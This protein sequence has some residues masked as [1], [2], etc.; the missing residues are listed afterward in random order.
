MTRTRTRGTST[1]KNVGGLA[2]TEEFVDDFLLQSS[3][4]L[5]YIE[6][7]SF[8][9]SVYSRLTPNNRPISD[10]NTSLS[11]LLFSRVYNENCFTLFKFSICKCRDAY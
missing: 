1:L 11:F 7:Y 9:I 3:L 6:V 8:G 10:T 5:G 4:R 2:M